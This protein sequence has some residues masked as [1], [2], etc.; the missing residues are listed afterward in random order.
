[1]FAQFACHVGQQVEG[2]R[3]SVKLAAAVIGQHDAVDAAVHHGAGVVECL[4]PFDNEL[5]RP[6]RL[7]PGQIVEGEAGVEHGVQVLADGARPAIQ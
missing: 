7:D 3:G 5:A 4:D 1:M 6:L 2:Y